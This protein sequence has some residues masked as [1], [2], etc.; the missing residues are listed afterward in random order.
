VS[1]FAGE[2]FKVPRLRLA[3]IGAGD[4]LVFR[5]SGSKEVIQTLADAQI[6]PEAHAIR[7]QAARWHEA[8]RRSGHDEATLL[9]ELEQVKC[10]RTLQTVRGWL[11][12]D[13]M[14]GP[15]TKA[16]L[17]AIAYAVGD[18]QLLDDVPSIWAAIHLLRGEH[19]KAGMSLS[20]ILLEKLPER[21]EEMQ[22]GRTRIEIDNATSAWI[23]QV[24]SIGD[25]EEL[26]PRSL[27]NALL[28]VTADFA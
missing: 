25:T 5:E 4:V 7:A 23:V 6:G 10:P 17:E 21:L 8:L 12:D 9:R 20:R 27:V 16:D 14:I 26:R 15:Q 22:E 3:E 18:Q 24:E 13:S 19:L 1:G 28:W 11:A 2:N